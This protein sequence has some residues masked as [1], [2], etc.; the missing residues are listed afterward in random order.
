MSSTVL[1]SLLGLSLALNVGLLLG[2]RWTPETPPA[3]DAPADDGGCLLDQLQLDAEQREQLGEMRRKM[4]EKRAA[5]WRRTSALRAELA[6]AI[7]AADE[8]EAD[9]DAELE[10]YAENQVAMQRAVA[11][12]LRTVNA[13]LR[14]EQRATFRAL[15]RR[16]MFGGIRSSEPEREDA[17]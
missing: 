7:C 6:D 13:M 2:H 5:Y 10:H 11:E 12:H 4:H 16:Q 3:S 9:L 15:L 8:E 1:L 17:Q 14:P